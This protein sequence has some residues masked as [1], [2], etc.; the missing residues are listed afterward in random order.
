[1]EASLKCTDGYIRLSDTA[2]LGEPFSSPQMLFDDISA[3]E[4]VEAKLKD[5]K[6]FYLLVT[7]LQ[8][9]PQRYISLKAWL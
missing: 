6:C 1:M 8:V 2:V 7:G 5:S 3:S 4:L 9:E